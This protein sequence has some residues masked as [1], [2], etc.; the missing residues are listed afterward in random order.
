MKVLLLLHRKMNT[1]THFLETTRGYS[2]MFNTRIF[3]FRK[4]WVLDTHHWWDKSC[5]SEPDE[6]LF[7]VR[8]PGLRPRPITISWTNAP[9]NLMQKYSYHRLCLHPEYQWRE[10]NTCC[11]TAIESL[12]QYLRS[13]RLNVNGA[14]MV[15]V[16]QSGTITVDTRKTKDQKLRILI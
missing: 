14:I 4:E 12:D 10:S 15:G 6:K 2:A 9:T 8:P 5:D 16:V 11:R 7:T 1:M 13:C 3:K